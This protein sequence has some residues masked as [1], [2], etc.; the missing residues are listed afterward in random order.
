M[1]KNPSKIFILCLLLFLVTATMPALGSDW[2]QFQKDVY[3]TG[4]T[5]DRAPI[6]DPTNS[7]LSWNYTLGGNIDSAP[8]VA[9]DIVYAVAGDKHMYAFNKATGKL[10]W[11]NSISGGTNFVIGSGAVGNGIIF[12]PTSDGQIFAFDAKTGSLNWNKA[13]GDGKQLDTPILY[14]EGKIY[15]GEAMGG[16]KYY[17]YD[18]SGNEVW[19]RASTTQVSTEG[20]YYWAGAALIGNNLVYG[21]DDGH[22]VSVNK[23]TGADIDEV[24]VSSEFGVT[25][26]KIRSSVLYVEDLKRIYFTS[27]GGYCFALGFD[28]A[29]GT[30][31]NSDKH[32]IKVA[33]STSTPAFYKGR[34]YMG[35][36][37]AMGGAGKGLYC[38]DADLDGVIWDYPAGVVQS[39]PAIS[40]YY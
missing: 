34:I 27:S 19:S 30:F 8:L 26:G 21:D 2:T 10:V 33:Y 35:T 13:V 11:D 39:S 6:T 4:V 18:E 32:S 29:K 15:F 25:S 38:L 16:H 40:T 23:D 17:C 28:A 7:S 12:V 22:L 3:N 20:S 14:S 37:A 9:G 36:G 31:D 1:N 24:D 5:A